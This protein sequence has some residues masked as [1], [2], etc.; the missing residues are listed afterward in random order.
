[1]ALGYL[2]LHRSDQALALLSADPKAF[3][4]LTWI[5][6]RASRKTGEALIGD[7][8]V[9]GATSE[10]AY[11][12]AKKRLE[13]TGLATFKPTSKGTIAKLVNTQVFDIN[14]IDA[15]DQSD[16]QPD[17]QR[18]KNPTIKPTTN[19]KFKKKLNTRNKEYTPR[20]LE[21][22]EAFPKNR[23]GNKRPAFAEWQ[24]IPPELHQQIINHVRT[25]CECDAEWLKENFRYVQHA[26]RFL[27]HERF[28][29]QFEERRDVRERI[30]DTRWSTN[31]KTRG[32]HQQPRSSQRSGERVIRDIS[33]DL[34]QL[35]EGQVG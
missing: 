21:F 1:M 24:K 14:M 20:F 30:F 15:D 3:N 26:E 6:F 27:K 4:L 35:D 9:M 23:R 5:A 7:W 17:D 33:H 8:K 19:K 32:S 16:E 31:E 25:R 29:D 28:Y 18:V 2:K 12:R 34:P 10:A 13:A 22:W 11:R